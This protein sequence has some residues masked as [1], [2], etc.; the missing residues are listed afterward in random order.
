MSIQ[1][2]PPLASSTTISRNSSFDAEG[3]FSFQLPPSNPPYSSG[4]SVYPS[5]NTRYEPKLS[6]SLQSFPET[7]SYN[8]PYSSSGPQANF[9]RR[10]SDT[11]RRASSVRPPVGSESEPYRSSGVSQQAYDALYEEVLNLRQKQDVLVNLLGDL[12]GVLQ[13]DHNVQCENRFIPIAH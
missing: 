2:P 12:Y 7:P 13:R 8:Y 3:A 11:K 10:P 5:P 1:R 6:P 4:S 9:D